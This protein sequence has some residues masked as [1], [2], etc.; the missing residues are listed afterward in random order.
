MAALY[1]PKATA[2]RPNGDTWEIE[3]LTPIDK[4]LPQPSETNPQKQIR[5]IGLACHEAENLYLSDEVLR[6][7]GTNW[8]DA[9]EAIIARASQH[10]NKQK[11]LEE[12]PKWDRQKEDLK[13]IIEEIA[14][15]IDPKKCSLD[16]ARRKSNWFSTP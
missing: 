1:F 14:K 12:A 7:K 9:T 11:L 2:K 6:S 16:S 10:G 4:S 8:T 5:F 15:S 13:T 3:G